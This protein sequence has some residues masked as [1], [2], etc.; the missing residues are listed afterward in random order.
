MYGVVVLTK[1]SLSAMAA[2]GPL[3]QLL[4]VGISK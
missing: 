4:E 2:D 3:G 1:L